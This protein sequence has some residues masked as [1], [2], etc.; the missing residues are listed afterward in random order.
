MVGVNTKQRARAMKNS[1]FAAVL[2]AV[3]S[4]TAAS[5]GGTAV[6]VSA[7]SPTNA[8]GL[9]RMAVVVNYGDID[10]AGREGAATLLD[11]IGRAASL[12]C[13]ERTVMRASGAA[14]RRF[15]ACR[16]QAIAEAV[17]AVNTPSL[18]QLA[19]AQ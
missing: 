14:E 16:T 11:R 18:S 17:A 5:A 13:G 1:F 7:M 15:A 3:L 9:Q 19:A 10:P 12:V 6:T 4:A 2:V 8:G